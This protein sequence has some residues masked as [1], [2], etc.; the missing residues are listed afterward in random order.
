MWIQLAQ[1]LGKAVTSSATLSRPSSLPA[2]PAEPG[3][4]G[5]VD[6]PS[7]LGFRSKVARKNSNRSSS[8]PCFP[9]KTTSPGTNT[10]GLEHFRPFKPRG[11]QQQHSHHNGPSLMR[12]DSR[13]RA[14]TNTAQTHSPGS[15]TSMSISTES[16]QYCQ[17]WR[18]INLECLLVFLNL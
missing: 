10:R 3:A 11:A 8:T 16:N 2:L 9:S 12:D 17:C 15:V 18:I 1:T 13:T 5:T 14:R 6:W 7:S 4:G